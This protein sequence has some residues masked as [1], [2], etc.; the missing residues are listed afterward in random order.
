LREQLAAAIQLPEV[1]GTQ[2]EPALGYQGAPETG[3]LVGVFQSP[4]DIF[5]LQQALGQLLEHQSALELQLDPIL[6]ETVQQLQGVLAVVARLQ[7]FVTAQGEPPAL[8]QSSGQIEPQPGGQ[9]ILMGAIQLKGAVQIR[10]GE[11]QPALFS[12][13]ATAMTEGEAQQRFQ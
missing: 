5:Q 2:V 11:L 13:D 9:L 6:L 12:Q 10:F 3:G 4:V 8:T 7:S 1:E